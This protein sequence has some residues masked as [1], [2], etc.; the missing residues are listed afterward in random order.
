MV[1]SDRLV[2]IRINVAV[3]L[4]D[5]QSEH[6]VS[7]LIVRIITVDLLFNDETFERPVFDLHDIRVIVNVIDIT[8]Q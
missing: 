6:I 2:E 8:D 3:V 5:R 4:Q 1:A 7:V